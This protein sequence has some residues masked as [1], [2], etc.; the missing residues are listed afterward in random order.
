MATQSRPCSLLKVLAPVLFQGREA[1]SGTFVA[2]EISW[3]IGLPSL[4][5]LPPPWREGRG[6]HTFGSPGLCGR[7]KF[8]EAQEIRRAQASTVP[9][10]S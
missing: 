4:K 9:G 2:K 7:G 8:H 5:M 1:F 6:S 10:P 3:T